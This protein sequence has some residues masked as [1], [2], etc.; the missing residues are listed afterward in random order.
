MTTM[1]RAFIIS[2]LLVATAA[3]AQRHRAVHFPAPQPVPV[4]VPVP[5]PATP[6]TVV[7]TPSKDNTLFESSNGS[8]SNGTGIHLFAGKTNGSLIRR[9]LLAFDVASKVPA[10]SQITNVTL[11]LEVTQSVA[12]TETMALHAVSADWGEGTSNA[13][14]FRDGTGTTAKTGDATWIHRFSP[15]TRWIKVGGDFDASTDATAAASGS[16]TQL[17]FGPSAAL[18]A[19]VQQWL[20]QPSTNFGWIITGNESASRSTKQFDSRESST[21][22]LRPTLTIDYLPK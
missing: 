7:L 21:T 1:R 9:A 18:I 8:I 2:V 11:T 15:N 22:E 14:A 10:N 20:D 17:T 3:A 16:F 19:R 5:V 6:Q 13:G 4:P 12:G